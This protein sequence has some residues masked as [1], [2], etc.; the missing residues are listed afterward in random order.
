MRAQ[1][2]AL[3]LLGLVVHG[4]WA[5]T[6]PVPLDWDPQYYRLVATRIL[7]GEGASLPVV[8]TLSAVPQA[9]PAPADLHWMPLP[10]RVLLPGLLLWPEHGDQLVTVGLAACWGPL[11]LGLAR[12]A[13]APREAA[14]LGGLCASLGAGW[15]R[16]LSTPDSMALYG[17]LG[18]LAFL[19]LA[20]RQLPALLGLSALAALTRGDGFLLGLALA[21]GGWRVLGWRGALLVAGSGLL[22]AGAWQLRGVLVAGE[23]AL[24]GRRAAAGALDMAA[25]LEGTAGQAGPVERVRFALSEVD[26]GLRTVLV[27]GVG[28]LPP[29][30]LGGLWLCRQEAWARAAAVYAVLL[31]TVPLLLAPAVAASG[32]LFRSGA[33][34][35]PAGCALAGLACWRVSEWAVARRGYPRALLPGFLVVAVAV[36]SLGMGLGTLAAREAPELDCAA[37]PEG[38]LV[39]TREPL[40]WGERCGAAA[41]YLPEGDEARTQALRRFAH[42]VP[43]GG[44]WLPPRESSAG[45]GG[46]S[47][48]HP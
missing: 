1:V 34:L 40:A 17:T 12:A 22:A 4:L 7:A 42:L 24:E 41:V 38:A 31:G 20:R 23:L 3:A 21:L 2:L 18:G 37:V 11:A 15:V 29:L 46:G 25:F 27:A 43:P 16:F 10:S 48:R 33:A 36:G 35:A 39:T 9:L 6:L 26:D 44:T 19:A 13:G 45:G 32:T 30:A 8:W 5:L 47:S 28:V 14:L